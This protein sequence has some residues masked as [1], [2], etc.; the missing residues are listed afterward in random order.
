MCHLGL[1]LD[2]EPAGC[3]GIAAVMAAMLGNGAGS[4]IPWSAA[5]GYTGPVIA[6]E[7]PASRLPQGLDLL[8][9]ALAEP[10]FEPSEVTRQIQRAIAGVT[11]ASA[12]PAA[13]LMRELPAAIYGDSSRAGRPCDGSA[14]T[15]ARLTPDDVASFFDA[16]VRPGSTT[17]VI[18]GDLAGLNAVALTAGTLGTWED[19]R[20][21]GYV[22]ETL[23]MPRRFPAA[24]LVDQP[25]AAQTH[26][27]LA[28]AV[29]GRSFPSGW[30][31]MQVAAYILGAQAAGRLDAGLQ[32]NDGRGYGIRVRLTEP[33]P[34][35]G[36][37]QI[38][39]AVPAQATTGVLRDLHA[40]IRARARD[41]FT[42]AEVTAAASAITRTISLAYEYPGAIAAITAEHVACRLPADFP[43]RVRDV[44]GGLGTSLVNGAYRSHIEVARLS[45]IAVGDAATLAGPLG[46]LANPV[47]LQVTGS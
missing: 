42:P 46:D 38:S 18:A 35:A 15:L 5:A 19:L 37:L 8:R 7:L 9:Q 22:T 45:L 14:A 27:L 17:V 28:A 3:D 29:T 1:P 26:L 21:T 34:G 6:C 33:V 40:V 44:I 47:A 16:W 24:V 4:G 12:D 43:D 39:G 31:A 11:R 36:L 32:E 23:P 20:A 13:R 30:A 2:C 41:G 25:G 10:A